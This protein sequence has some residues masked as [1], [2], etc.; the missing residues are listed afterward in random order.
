MGGPAVESVKVG[1][2]PV[3][4]LKIFR[5]FFTELHSGIMSPRVC[6]QICRSG[7]LAVNTLQ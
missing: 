2:I 7:D 4:S 3:G 6:L 5:I 1:W